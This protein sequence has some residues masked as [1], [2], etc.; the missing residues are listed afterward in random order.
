MGDLH[1]DVHTL[2]RI[3]KHNGMP[4]KAR[5]L[6]LGDYVDRCSS[7]EYCVLLLLLLWP[8]LHVVLCEL[9]LGQLILAQIAVNLRIQLMVVLP[10]SLY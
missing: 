1:G 9:R 5:Y 6:F 2:I 3:L 4:P 10:R 7:P 8:R